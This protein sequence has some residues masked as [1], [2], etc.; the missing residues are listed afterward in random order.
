[1]RQ[2]ALCFAASSPL[3]ARL[4]L[5]EVFPAENVFVVAYGNVYAA[6]AFLHGLVVEDLSQET[7]R[8]MKLV[9]AR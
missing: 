1:M 9:A 4:L 3:S 8:G 6:I 2:G 7:L 5:E